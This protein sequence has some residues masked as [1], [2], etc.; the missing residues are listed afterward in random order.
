M[1]QNKED[2]YK[3]YSEIS[4]RKDTFELQIC[5]KFIYVSQYKSPNKFH[6]LMMRLFF[7]WKFTLIK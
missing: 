7:G 3:Y 2:Q 4:S 5:E 6:R 1:N